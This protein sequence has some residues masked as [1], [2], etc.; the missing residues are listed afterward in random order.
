MRLV[1]AI[2]GLDAPPEARFF[3]SVS[4]FA[5]VIAVIYWFVSYEIAGTILLGG[6]G[7]G[8]GAMG[9]TLAANAERRRA[10]RPLPPIVGGFAP[11]DGGTPPRGDGAAGDGSAPDDLQR[12]FLDESGRV[13]SPTFAPFALGIGVAVAATSLV[14]GPAPLVVG[15]V[16]ILWG[17]W[18]WMTGASDELAATSASDESPGTATSTPSRVALGETR[19]ERGSKTAP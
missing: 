6:F 7:L 15:V 3:Q 11:G 8:S 10:T 18:R 4:A 9:F 12:P 2:L 16:P 17:A 19:P 14:F 5:I 13:P 1:R